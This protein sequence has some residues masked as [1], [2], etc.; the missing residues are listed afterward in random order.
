[1]IFHFGLQ[2]SFIAFND[3]DRPLDLRLFLVEFT[4]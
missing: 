1:M 2:Q 3:D 4:V